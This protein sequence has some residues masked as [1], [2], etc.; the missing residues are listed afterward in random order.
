MSKSTTQSQTDLTDAIFEV[1]KIV[2]HRHSQ[3]EQNA[4]EYLIK[5]KGYD[6]EFNTWE[7]E[8]NV[9]AKG[10]INQYWA[11]Q[12]YTLTEFRKK[13]PNNEKLNSKNKNKSKE[14]NS[15]KRKVSSSHNSTKV[16]RKQ[17]IQEIKASQISSTPP[18]GYLWSD[19][20]SVVNVFYNEPNVYFAEV[21]WSQDEQKNTYIPTRILKKHNPLKLIYFY[22]KRLEFYLPPPKDTK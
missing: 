1:E 10:L 17:I 8:S 12:P 15:L 11:N 21:K 22:E 3:R 9:Y 5:W 16:D 2:G 7:R 6:E 19:I 13:H 20:D 4:V 14:S 18:A